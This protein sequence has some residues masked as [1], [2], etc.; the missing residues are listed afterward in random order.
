MPAVF[1]R[2]TTDA[3][4]VSCFGKGEGNSARLFFGEVLAKPRIGEDLW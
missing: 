4:R 2:L 3:A 1:A